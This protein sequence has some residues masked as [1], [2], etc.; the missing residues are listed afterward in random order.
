MKN[1]HYC[2]R[3]SLE[4]SLFDIELCVGKKLSNKEKL[5]FF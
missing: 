4:V 3:D 2:Q 5:D 1:V